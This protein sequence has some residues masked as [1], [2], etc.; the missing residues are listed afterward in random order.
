[1]SKSARHALVM[2]P[3]PWNLAASQYPI[4]VFLLRQLIS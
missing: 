1:M 4:D 3:L 2:I